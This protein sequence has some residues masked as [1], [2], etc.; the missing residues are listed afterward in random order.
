M[1]RFHDILAR[2]RADRRYN[3]HSHTQFCDGHA[4]M[5]SMVQGAIEA[6]L[7]VYGFSPHAPI[8]LDSPCNMAAA[9]VP[10]FKEEAERLRKKYA[11]QIDIYTGMEIDYLSPDRGPAAAHVAAWCLDYVIGS[12]HFVPSQDGVYADTDGRPERFRRYVQEVFHGDLRYVVQTFFR[13]T[14][15]MIAAGGLD[16]IGH[17]DKIGL[18]ASS[19]D[20][21]VEARPWYRREI[22]ETID[23]IAA[24]GLVAEINTK[25]RAS[26]GRF[27]PRETLWRRLVS[28]GVPIIVNSDAHDPHLT[29]ASRAEAFAILDSL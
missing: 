21:D 5:E 16:I 18:N 6:G 8:D 19:V 1:N 22:D 9:D 17:F 2:I 26:Y 10:T 13:Q 23:C 3:L 20:A 11:G 7:R 12:V 29:D 27:F 25:A 24:S 15:D 28:A 4:D 14:R